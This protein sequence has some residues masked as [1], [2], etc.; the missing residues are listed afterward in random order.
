MRE[1]ERENRRGVTRDK[2]Q[3]PCFVNYIYLHLSWQFQSQYRPNLTMVTLN[4]GNF[5]AAAVVKV[6]FSRISQYL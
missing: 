5:Y 6:G 1:G 3:L 2:K 4:A